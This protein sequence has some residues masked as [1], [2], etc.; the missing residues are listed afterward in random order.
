MSGVVELAEGDPVHLVARGR[1]PSRRR[2]AADDL[3][4]AAA[5]RRAASRAPRP[6]RRACPRSRA[7]ERDDRVDAEHDAR[8]AAPARPPPRLAQRV[9]DARPPAAAPSSTRRR[10]RR[11]HLE[12]DA[13]SPRGSRAAAAS[14]WRG[15]AAS[16]SSGNQIPISRAA[17]SGESEPWTMFWPTSIAK[18]PRIE[19]VVASSGFV[20]PITWRAAVDGLVALEHHRDERRGG[21][22]VDELA[23][24]RPLRVLGVVRLGELARRRQRA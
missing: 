10:R 24:E 1:S 21:D 4:G 18:S 11:S 17:D 2:Q 13:E 12:G 7:V 15:Q 22:E 8:P 23:E 9:L 16:R 5:Q 19:P 3:V 14:G 20:A 6:R